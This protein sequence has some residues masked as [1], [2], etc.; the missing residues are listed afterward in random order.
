MT[1]LPVLCDRQRTGVDVGAKVGMYTY[2]IRANSS[3]VVAFEPIPMFNRMLAAVFDGKR[4]R[5]EPFAVSSQPGRVTMRLPYDRANAQQ[6]GRATI[7]PT[8]PL[9]HAMVARVEELEVEARTIDSYAWHAVGFIKVDVE[10]HELAVL[11]GAE[12]TLAHH[13]PNLLVEC[14]HEHNQGGPARLASWLA[15]HGYQ[16]VFLD[17]DRLTPIEQYDPDVHWRTRGIENFLCSHRSRPEVNRRL[18]AH[19]AR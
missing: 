3:D 2:R 16:A 17:G 1:C 15:D 10:G 9:T 5:I 4:G 14:N 18:A 8:N 6:F 11:A 13:R 7:E 19:V 12:K